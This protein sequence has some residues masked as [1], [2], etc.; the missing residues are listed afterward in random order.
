MTLMK[1]HGRESRLLGL[2][3][4]AFPLNTPEFWLRFF[5]PRFGT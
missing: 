3:D 4:R 2:D 5:T 1:K